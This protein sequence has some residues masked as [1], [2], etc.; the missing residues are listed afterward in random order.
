MYLN[1]A[2]VLGNLTRDPELKA[3]P[4]GT[5]VCNFSVATNRKWTKDGEKKEEVE[6]HN[7]I[8][9]GKTGELIAQYMHKGSQILVEG[10]IQTRSW[11]KDGEK[12]YRTEI[13]VDSMQFG[14]KTQESSPQQASEE[15]RNK[16]AIE[17]F[18][19]NEISPNDIPW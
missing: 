4:S 17:A 16:K 3:L 10:R 2:I 6:Y 13:V 19:E 11:D 14:N 12:R 15:D 9:F 18:N 8:A 5:Q 7:C 1:K